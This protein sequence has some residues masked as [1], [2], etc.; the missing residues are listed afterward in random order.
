MFC[1]QSDGNLH[2]L[3]EFLS[4]R[5]FWRDLAVFEVEALIKTK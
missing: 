3:F 4:F 2:T 5:I 1:V